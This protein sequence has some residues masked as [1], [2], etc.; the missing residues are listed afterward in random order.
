[1][2]SPGQEISAAH[3]FLA[4]R[5]N[6]GGRHPTQRR[7]QPVAPQPPLQGSHG[8]CKSSPVSMEEIA[9]TRDFSGL[10]D[11]AAWGVPRYS[12][13]IIRLGIV[14]TE[15]TLEPARG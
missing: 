8:W 10:A 13:T 6:M 2:G 9:E 4:G 11:A 12:V 1:M 14:R 15:L 5:G 7:A 3:N